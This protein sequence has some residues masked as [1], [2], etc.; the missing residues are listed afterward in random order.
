MLPEFTD[1][2]VLKDDICAILEEN[3]AKIDRIKGDIQELSDSADN[4]VKVRKPWS[5]SYAYVKIF[6]DRNWI[7]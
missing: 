6:V 3:G 2:D 7:L 5:S 1:V 4:I